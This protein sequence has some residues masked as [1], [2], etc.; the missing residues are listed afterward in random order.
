MVFMMNWHTERIPGK[1]AVR[2]VCDETPCCSCSEEGI[3]NFRDH[4][5]RIGR[6]WGGIILW[7]EIPRGICPVCHSIQRI[8]PTEMVPFKHYITQIIAGVLSG[9]ISETELALMNYPAEMTARRWRAWEDAGFP[10]LPA[11]APYD[12]AAGRSS[13]E[14]VRL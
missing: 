8:L 10:R 1:T 14:P 2:F 3:L 6:R 9:S 13:R 7:Y 12:F 4:V 5:S 11:D